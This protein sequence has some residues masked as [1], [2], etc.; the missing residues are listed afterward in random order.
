MKK[1]IIPAIVA[2]MCAVTSLANAA[3]STLPYVGVSTGFGLLNN[4]TVD[5]LNDAISYKT[6]YLINGAVGLKLDNYRVE[7]ELG[8]H[9]NSVDSA[10]ISGFNGSYVNLWTY[11][12]NGYYDIKIKN[13]KF[14]PYVMG[15]LG[16]AH[17]TLDSNGSPSSTKFAWQLGAGVSLKATDLI[18]IDL[19]YRYLQP[20]DASFNGAKVSLASSNIVAGIRTTFQF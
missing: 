20:S 9:S 12:A 19:G 3:E 17:A 13:S 2:G 8:Y 1:I 14:S 4:S 5:G 7:A 16:I 6:G 18:N 11:M 10:K 15:G